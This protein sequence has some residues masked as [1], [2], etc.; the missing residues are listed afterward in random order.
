MHSI[1]YSN[2]IVL[3]L[4][5]TGLWICP[6]VAVAEPV[7]TEST[8]YDP[9]KGNQQIKKLIGS[10]DKKSWDPDQYESLRNEIAGHLRQGEEQQKILQKEVVEIDAALKAL[11]DKVEGESARM[12]RERDG[13]GSMRKLKEAQLGEYRLLAINGQEALRKLE[14]KRQEGQRSRVLGK[15]KPLWEL[16]TELRRTPGE[17]LLPDWTKARQGILAVTGHQI[18]ALLLAVCLTIWL[19]GMLAVKIERYLNMDRGGSLGRFVALINRHSLLFRLGLGIVVGTTAV[20]WLL[21]AGDEATSFL[22]WLSS[23]LL[24]AFLLPAL[25]ESLCRS[26]GQSAHGGSLNILQRWM[27]RCAA[28][29]AALVVFMLGAPDLDLVPDAVALPIR[30]VAVGSTIFLTALTIMTI[31]GFFPVLRATGRIIR[32][33]LFVAM[34]VVL[35]LEIFGFRAFSSHLLAGF[36][37]S[38]VLFAA[39]VMLLDIVQWLLA[40]VYDNRHR[41]FDR[42]GILLEDGDEDELLR[43]IGWLRAIL[44]FII[45][46]SIFLVLVAIWDFAEV[47]ARLLLGFLVNGFQIGKLLIVPA[48]I[49]L[50]VFLFIVGWSLTLWI[51]KIL[52]RKWEQEAVFAES[53]REALLTVTGYVCYVVAAIAGLSIAG[54]NFSGLAVIAGALSVG[55]GFGLQ[56]IV[57]N[58]VSGLILLFEQPIKRGDWIVA[59]STEGYVKKISVRSTIIQTFD[60]ADVI[61]P[62]SELISSPVTNMMFNDH[63]GRLKVSVGVAYG[64]DTALVRRLLLEI[65]NGHDEV[66]VD[67]SSPRPDVVFQEF[68]ESSLNFDLFCH[69]KTID[70]RVRV[71]SEMNYLIDEA[72]RRHGI[73]IPFPQRDIHIRTTS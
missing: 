65:A 62:N 51:K 44:K 70:S 36:A 28:A 54:V 29:G 7:S 23:A 30:F 45:A 49:V 40:I 21:L 3:I 33:L 60:R 72:F 19:F 56:N 20:S 50:G 22:P 63:R 32:F 43:G 13:L 4:L 18:V 38:F 15:E 52:N 48:R 58:F 55:I 64:S 10:L 73:E 9:I 53:T 11:G 17:E 6:V 61:V 25:V 59:G 46:V 37:W 34:V 41:M 47:Y 35:Y 67:G 69:L 24:V 1:R 5:M 27:V 16:V 42:L 26:T 39:T 57:N 14:V 71:R 66:I 68:A 8:I 31:S 2:L 12:A